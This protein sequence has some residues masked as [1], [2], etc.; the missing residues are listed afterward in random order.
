MS[1][2]VLSVHLTFLV[3]QEHVLNL[4]RI[5]ADLAAQRV[6]IAR[7]TIKQDYRGPVVG[8]AAC[9]VLR[10]LPHE[11]S[12]NLVTVNLELELVDTTCGCL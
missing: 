2:L 6:S 3:H 1:L 11:S 5:E 10:G 9:D 8:L 7:F 12:I 4:S